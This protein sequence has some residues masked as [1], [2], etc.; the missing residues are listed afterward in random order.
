MLGPVNLT[1]PTGASAVRLREHSIPHHAPSGTYLYE[2]R[3]GIYPNDVWSDDS[4]TFEKLAEDDLLSHD[5]GWALL[6]LDENEVIPEAAPTEYAL[7]PAHPNPFNPTTTIS[8]QLSTISN[9]NLAVYDIGGRMVAQ[10]VDGVREA[11]R[12]EVIFDA[13]NL[14]SGVYFSRIIADD[15]QQTQK[16]LLVK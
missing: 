16:L 14:S 1:M 5:F 10:L 9:V 2:G 3:A 6:G 7:C 15:F 12:H 13:S 4:F 11:G 8:Y